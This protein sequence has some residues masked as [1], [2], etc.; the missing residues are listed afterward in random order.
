[1][2]SL[3]A[4]V[5]EHQLPAGVT[6]LDPDD[7]R[8]VDLFGD[9]PIVDARPLDDV[10]FGDYPWWQS[11]PARAS[12]PLAV[13]EE[14]VEEDE[15]WER[16]AEQCGFG[17]A[18]EALL[19]GEGPD[20]ED[21]EDHVYVALGGCPGD[22]RPWSVTVPIDYNESEASGVV[23]YDYF[24]YEAAVAEAHEAHE[25]DRERLFET[26]YEAREAD[27]QARRAVPTLNASVAVRVWRG[28][29][30]AR[31]PRGRRISRPGSRA[32]SPG[33][34]AAGDDDSPPRP[35]VAVCRAD[36]RL[37]FRARLVTARGWKRLSVDVLDEAGVELDRGLVTVPYRDRAGREL[38]RKCFRRDG[39]A[40]YRPAGTEL[41]PFGLET[42][43]APGDCHPRYCAL[44]VCEGESDALCVRD[45]LRLHDDDRAVEYLSLALPGVGVP[46]VEY[47]ALALPGASV[48]RNSWRS[49]VEPFP[50]VY[51]LGDG[52][53]PGRRMNRRVVAAVPWAR[54]V[55]LPDGADVRSLLQADPD[56]LEPLLAHADENAR[57]SAAL[58]LSPDLDTFRRLLAG[59]KDTP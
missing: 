14:V 59:G 17:P 40:F 4:A 31:A 34:L 2:F 35:R 13:P 42:L 23:Q 8:Y 24:A 54:P 50:L 38:Y 6:R 25:R 10:P 29:A 3:A 57:L 47:L 49:F 1:M 53:E 19:F 27:L 44:L 21:V 36:A 20:R 46:A 11:V 43:P 5:T 16:Y 51:V 33:R 52:D 30:R 58:A 28:T 39:R 18:E 12:A 9:L 45:V 7:Q 37:A 48:W 56:S 41:V 22:E 26:L 55:W 32:R 15:L